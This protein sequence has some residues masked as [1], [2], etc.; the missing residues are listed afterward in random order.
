MREAF[1]QLGWEFYHL[2]TREDA[3][4]FAARY[5]EVTGR[6]VA[7]FEEELTCGGQSYTIFYVAVSP[8]PRPVVRLVTA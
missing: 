1:T 5:R 7:C 4:P 2:P 6:E 8:R 3:G